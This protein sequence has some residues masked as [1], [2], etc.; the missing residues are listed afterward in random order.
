[1]RHL[2][3]S[4][5]ILLL[6]VLFGS[7]WGCH[8]LSPA[9][10]LRMV[11]LDKTVPFENR[12]EHR[13]LYWLLDHLRL[14]KEDGKPFDRDVDYRGAFPGPVPGDPPERTEPLTRDDVLAADVVYLADTYGVYRDDLKSGEAMKAALERSPKIYGGLDADEARVV[15]EALGSGKTVLAEFNSMASPTGGGP[16]Q[17][18]EETVGVRWTRWIGRYFPRL[19][20]RE[21]V[22]EWMRRNYRNEWKREWDFRGPGYVLVRDDD[23]IEVLSV[24]KEAKRV[25]L[26]L[27]RNEPHDPLLARARDNIAYPY[28]FDVVTPDDDVAVLA[29]FRWDLEDA[30]VARL[31]AR[32]LPRTFPAVTRRLAPGGGTAYYFA[33]DFA[34]NP[35]SDRRVP[36][37]GYLTVKRWSESL[38]LGPSENEFYWTFYV[39]MMERILS[40]NLR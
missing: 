27:S 25:S 35:M 36:L 26:T 16:R 2:R 13:S 1:M 8:V 18:L 7:S 40:E 30:G 24:G 19:E 34:D 39:P 29:S 22:P 32:G 38:R 23:A 14:V 28:W 9:R 5:P 31:K 11:V 4:W 15:Q 3:W 17:I 10:E 33:G 12:I 37:A 6:L 20:S 21:E